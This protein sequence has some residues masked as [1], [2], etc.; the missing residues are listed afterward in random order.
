M[1][2]AVVTGSQE[3]A[4]PVCGKRGSV[5]QPLKPQLLLSCLTS[6][7]GLDLSPEESGDFVAKG[8]LSEPGSLGLNPSTSSY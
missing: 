5:L 3:A 7:G 2:V 6:V 1:L 4:R 8:W